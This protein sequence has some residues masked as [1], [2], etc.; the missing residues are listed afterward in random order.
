ML[1]QVIPVVIQDDTADADSHRIKVRRHRMGRPMVSLS[2]HLT[3]QLVSPQTRQ[4]R[5][6]D[7]M[8]QVA[9][10]IGR[11]H[12]PQALMTAILNHVTAAFAADRSA[13]FLHDPA[14]S[15]LYSSVAEGLD[16][17]GAQIRVPDD[18]GLCGR[19]F[20]NQE[21]LCIADTFETSEFDRTTA[22][23]TG[24]MPRSMLVVPIIYRLGRCDGVLEVMDERVG[25]FTE[26]DI[27]LLEAI[28]VQVGIS[29]DNARLVEA[30]KQQFDS[31]VRAFATALDARD[32]M[33]AIHS[34]N[35]ANYAM[36]IGAQLGLDQKAMELLRVAGLLHDVGKIGVPEAVLTKPGRLTDEEFVKMREHAAHSRRILSQIHFTDELDGMDELAAAHHERLDGSGYP[37]GL[38]AEQLPL[39]ARILAV[40]DVFD[41]LTQ[42]RHYR[43]GMTFAEALGLIDTMTPH[44][45]D[46][47]CVAALRRFLNA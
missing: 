19:V 25:Y 12:E 13:L 43:C 46:A 24:Y 31:F 5:Q 9:C 38:R 1:G 45:L 15:E 10:A 17:W 22:D 35:V 11:L 21:S 36:G 29:L 41:A 40:A 18:V 4:E 42:D 7:T 26:Q 14:E 3:E 34:V 28:A 20:Q 16:D 23:W 2:Q 6:L 44:Q 27:P 47:G 8:L 30:Q 39:P 32:P 37:D 33:T